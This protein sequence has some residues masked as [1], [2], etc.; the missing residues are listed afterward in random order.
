MV[1]EYLQ[2]SPWSTYHT[3]PRH[4]D[5]PYES[6]L[7]MTP[8]ELHNHAMGLNPLRVLMSDAVLD[9][10]EDDSGPP[11]REGSKEWEEKAGSMVWTMTWKDKVS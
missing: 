1:D 7:G 6:V 3:F 5:S 8:Q 10:D 9:E 2:L 4:P 11:L